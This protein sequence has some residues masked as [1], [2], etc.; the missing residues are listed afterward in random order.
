MTTVVVQGGTVTVDACDP[1][2]VAVDESPISV[3]GESAVDVSVQDSPVSLTVSS[4]STDVYQESSDVLVTVSEFASAHAATWPTAPGA[5]LTYDVNDRLER[6][7]YTDGSFKTFS[8]D[9]EGLLTLVSGEDS[10]GAT[11]TVTLTYSNGL[12]STVSRT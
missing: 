7:D 12:L 8:Y 3:S 5:T 9:T 1:V 10:T 11:R 6:V 2:T 4:A